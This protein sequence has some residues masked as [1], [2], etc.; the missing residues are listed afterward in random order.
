MNLLKIGL[1]FFVV[2]VFFLTIHYVLELLSMIKI[3]K[4]LKNNKKVLLEDEYILNKY[5]KYVLNTE[6]YKQLKELYDE[7]LFLVKIFVNIGLNYTDFLFFQSL[8]NK[9]QGKSMHISNKDVVFNKVK[10]LIL[11]MFFFEISLYSKRFGLYMS[12]LSIVYFIILF[13]YN[14]LF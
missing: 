3:K 9:Y 4:W 2:G 6:E 8:I 13:I 14:K 1:F 10:K 11:I 7:N 12:K 5:N